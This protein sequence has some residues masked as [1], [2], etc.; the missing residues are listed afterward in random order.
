MNRLTGLRN[1]H[2]VPIPIII[3]GMDYCWN[4]NLERKSGVFGEDPAPVP[5]CSPKIS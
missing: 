3:G 2:D 1:F 5:F 4:D